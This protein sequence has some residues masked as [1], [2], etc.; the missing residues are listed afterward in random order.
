MLENSLVVVLWLKMVKYF[1]VADEGLSVFVSFWKSLV[2]MWISELEHKYN[3][4]FY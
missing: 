1:S 4:H 2:R 3:I